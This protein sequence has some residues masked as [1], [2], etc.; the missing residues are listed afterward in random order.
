[1]ITDSHQQPS[2][3]QLIAQARTLLR[4]NLVY[5]EPFEQLLFEAECASDEQ[6]RAALS[7]IIQTGGHIK[8]I[9][10]FRACELGDDEDWGDDEDAAARLADA[11][12]FIA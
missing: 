10:D 1:M 3:E 12:H 4:G 9:R 6:L 8:P 11:H 2:F 7:H 5:L